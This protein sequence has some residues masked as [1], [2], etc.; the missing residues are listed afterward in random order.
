MPPCSSFFGGWLIPSREKNAA[1]LLTVICLFTIN[2]LNGPNSYAG[3]AARG[4]TP[5][6]VG[7]KDQISGGGADDAG[8]LRLPQF[9]TVNY[10]DLTKIA[11]IS[12]FRSGAGHDYSDD[13]EKRRSMKHYFTPKANVVWSEVQIVSPVDGTVCGMT[14]EGLPHSGIQLCINSSRFPAFHFVIFH[15]NPVEN[16]KVGAAVTAGQ[17]LGHHI[18]SVTTS[19]IAVRVNTPA[20]SR[21][22]SYFALMT[23]ELFQT[24]QRRGIAN[25]DALI[26]TR[27]A[28]DADPLACVG[29]K[30]ESGGN[31]P[32]RVQLHDLL[33]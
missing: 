14:P 26:I 30:F 22:V 12:R 5:P 31:I 11:A 29:G 3:D 1:R 23:D 21:L 17:P 32:N 33:P 6:A 8:S 27:E 10:I 16:L 24:Y 7:P 13:F 15:V 9:V 20:G 18:G 28:R 4:I 19:D 2:A 25:R